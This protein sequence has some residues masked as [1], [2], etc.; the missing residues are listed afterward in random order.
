MKLCWTCWTWHV[1]HTFTVVSSAP[2]AGMLLF[3]FSPPKSLSTHPHRPWK[4]QL[5]VIKFWGR[6]R[7]NQDMILRYIKSNQEALCPSLPISALSSAASSPSLLSASLASQPPQTVAGI[8]QVKNCTSAS[9]NMLEWN[10]SGMVSNGFKQFPARCLRNY[11]TWNSCRVKAI[12]KHLPPFFACQ[13]PSTR[14]STCPLR[15]K[16]AHK[17]ETKKCGHTFWTFC[18]SESQV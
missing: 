6:G 16:P 13:T 7:P 14:S 15:R 11:E 17:Q 18:F 2:S 1:G 9:W 4:Q 8:L 10:K 3:L 12:P 5:N